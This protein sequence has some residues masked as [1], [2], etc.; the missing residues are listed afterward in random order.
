[1]T[2]TR[3]PKGSLTRPTVLDAAL[4]LI[5]RVGIDKLTIRGLARDL[6]RPPMTLYVH[7]GSKR[8]LLDLAYERLLH[9]LF[10]GG[11]HPTWQSQF[12]ATCRQ[13][14]RILL[15]HPHWVALLT[16]VNVPPSALEVYDR[17]LALMWKDGFRAEAAMLALSSLISH[18]L[19]SVLVQRLLGG[20]PPIPKRRLE[21]VKE[22][23]AKTPPRTYPRIAAVSPKFEGW[24]FDGVF[25]LGM[26][27]LI[28]G[29][30]DRA[31]RRSSQRRRA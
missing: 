31:P 9:R 7:F 26:R 23:L 1:M 5:D 12:E 30:D 10:A 25:E 29:L 24:S 20:K 13:I 3:S 21:L 6:A 2:R 11:H 8:E 22:M 18:A 19:G 17:L 28:A 4:A 15:E 27:A 16:R 14:R